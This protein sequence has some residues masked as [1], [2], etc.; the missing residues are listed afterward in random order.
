MQPTVDIFF[1]LVFVTTIIGTLTATILFF[2]SENETFPSRILA[3]FLLT[4]S[5][6]VLTAGGFF[7][8]I[9]LRYPHLSRLG[10][11]PSVCAMPLAYLY[12]RTVLEQEFRFKRYDFLF[13]IPIIV[14]AVSFAPYYFLSADEKLVY[15]RQILADRSLIALEPDGRLPLGWGWIFRSVYSFLFSLAQFK[16]LFDYRKRALKSGAGLTQNKIVFHWLTSFSIVVFITYSLV[17]FEV[18]LHVS[19]FLD[20]FRLITYTIIFCTLFV[21][22][23][24]FARPKILYG[25]TGYL[26]SD[27]KPIVQISS[28]ENLLSETH[29][30]PKS[31]TISREQAIIFRKKLEDF[32][33]EKKPFLQPGYKV[34]QL[35]D[36]LDIPFYQLSAFI[37]QEYGL[38]FN[39]LVNSFRV[40]YLEDLVKSN[41]EYSNYTLEALGKA[42]GFNS[43]ST[44][45]A[46]V[47]K[48]TG[49]TPQEFFS[50]LFAG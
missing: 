14:Y 34:K 37:N 41:S 33:G 43:R 27:E 18:V 38:N 42:A 19:R 4:I 26:Q 30:P 31:N 50:T 9:F 24:L 35:S 45:I 5:I 15:I 16:L 22:F 23:Y 25:L 40:Q 39:E 8:D 47:K 1:S 7:T 36:E 2:A 48:N 21:S 12:V 10:L 17:L 32:M 49:Q 29:E 20:L 44:F 6:T 46:A 28:K 11:I 3:F 13:F